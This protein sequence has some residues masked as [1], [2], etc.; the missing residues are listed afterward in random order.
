ME[1]AGAT[2]HIAAEVHDIGL[3]LSLAERGLGVALLPRQR[4]MAM[5]RPQLR[6]IAP[7]G[8]R[9]AM[10]ISLIQAS[11]LRALQQAVAWMAKRLAGQDR[12]P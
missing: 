12:Q 5:R 7:L 4:A 6:R 9:L 11:H 3:Q 10:R 2:L 8:L 1:S